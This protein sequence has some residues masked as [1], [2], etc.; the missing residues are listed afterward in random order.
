M[1]TLLFFESNNAHH[2]AV[3]RDHCRVEKYRPQPRQG[4]EANDKDKDCAAGKGLVAGVTG[5]SCKGSQNECNDLNSSDTNT[6][7]YPEIE[8]D[9]MALAPDAATNLHPASN[10]KASLDFG[11]RSIENRMHYHSDSDSIP[12]MVSNS[13]DSESD[14]G[15]K[16]PVYVGGGKRGRLGIDKDQ[17]P[18]DKDMADKELKEEAKRQKLEAAKQKRKDRREDNEAGRIIFFQL[19]DANIAKEVEKKKA[20]EATKIAKQQPP[21]FKADQAAKKA[22]IVDE[23]KQVEA[24][25]A[26]GDIVKV[27]LV[28]KQDAKKTPGLSLQSEKLNKTMQKE[29]LQ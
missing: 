19:R 18:S 29:Q 14:G 25:K 16:R 17:K 10:S 8:I 20:D 7:I 11:H 23:P 5:A 2:V 22:E 4:T 1:E 26:G 15:R 21:E 3:Q 6:S 12:D 9:K 24:G 13:E 27:L 28:L